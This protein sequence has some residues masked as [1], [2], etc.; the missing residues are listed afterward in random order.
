VFGLVSGMDE[1]KEK[2]L[3]PRPPSAVEKAVPGVKR[4]LSGMVADVLA[5]ATIEQRSPTL[6]RFRIGD[7][8]WCEPDYR[9][10]LIWAEATRKKSL[11]LRLRPKSLHRKSLS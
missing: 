8:E 4:I 6:A 9:Q 1:K 7:Y 2:A 3:V 10:I 11:N 5:Q